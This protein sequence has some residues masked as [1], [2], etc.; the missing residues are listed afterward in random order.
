MKKSPGRGIWARDF[1]NEFASTG[2]VRFVSQHSYPGGSAKKVTD[3]AAAR[4]KLLEPSINESYQK[5]YDTFVPA[6]SLRRLVEFADAHPEVGLIGPRLRDADGRW[7]ISYRDRP[8]VPALLHRL[9][10]FRWTGL[11]R[12]AY[13]HYRRL[14]FDPNRRRAVEVLMGA[15]VLVPRDLFFDCGRWDEGYAFGGEDIDLSLRINRCREVVYLPDVEI[16]H[17]GRASSRQR[18]PACRGAPREQCPRSRS[19]RPGSC[20][21]SSARRPSKPAPP[22]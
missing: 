10:V 4:D 3:V 5:M 21:R 18:A 7:Q 1:A 14:G 15:A 6:G 22:G 2:H 8:T 11:F 12:R 19:A 13:R 16:T 17:Y 9:L 20:S